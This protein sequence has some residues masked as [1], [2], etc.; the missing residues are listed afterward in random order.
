[1]AL[2]LSAELEAL[3]KEVREAFELSDNQH[4]TYRDRWSH[5]FGMYRSYEEFRNSYEGSSPRDKDLGLMDAKREWGAS[6]FIPYSFTVVETILPRM[7]SNRPRMLVL[8]RNKASEDNVE[9]MRATIDAQQE[10]I[11]YELKCQD[12][13][14]SGLIYGLG[15][16]KAYWRS[17]VRERS[18]LQPRIFGGWKKG[19]VRDGFDDPD[20]ENVDIFDFYWDPFAGTISQ[21]RY[22][23]HRTWRSTRYVLDRIESGAWNNPAGLDAEEIDGMGPSSKYGEIHGQRM[24]AAGMGEWDARGNQLHEMWEFHDGRRVITILDREVPVQ[25]GPNPAWHGE[26]PFAAYRPTTQGIN[27]LPGIGEIEPIE[28][29]QRE[30]NTLRSQRR[31]NATLKLQQVFAYAAG[32]VEASDLQFFPGSAIA[33]NGDPRE[34]LFPINV[35]DIPNSGY[36][37]EGG[38]KSDIEMT[39]GIS[40]PVTGGGDASQTAT[41]V[42]LLQAAANVRIQNKTRRIEVETIK[43][44]TRMFGALNQQKILENRDIRVPAPPV[45]GEPERRW[46]WVTIGPGELAGEFDFEPEGGSTAPENVPQQRQDAM[47]L[48]QLFGG[49]PDVVDRKRVVE[50]ALD[51]FGVKNPE[52]WLVPD[53]RIPLQ[54]LTLLEGAGV[55]AEGIAQLLEQ[56]R[57]MEEEAAKG[58]PNLQQPQEP[59]VPDEPQNGSQP[60]R[61]RA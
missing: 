51:L 9:N 5:L 33:V 17:D 30:M 61:A 12:T 10:R 20:V 42:Q 45:P 46:A 38:L 16:Q 22:V 15:I 36:Q 32:L 27:Q 29:L 14:K 21:C 1:M 41:G 7:M 58:S 48:M 43:P 26:L 60:E 28:H 47:Q 40:D 4:R 2:D 34:L 49:A 50:K 55:P 56:A 23:I 8:P 39:T 59:E 54:F 35:G 25:M 24:D 19:K 18:V 3:V 44:V 53:Q 31:D 37:E 52:T 13:A 6:L 11:S 57:Q